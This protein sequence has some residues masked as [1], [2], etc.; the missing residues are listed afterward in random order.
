MISDYHIRECITQAMITIQHW[1]SCHQDEL[2][3]LLAFVFLHGEDSE[4]KE[5]KRIADRI[6]LHYASAIARE[7]NGL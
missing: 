7:C 2:L 6:Q 3:G 5:A 1:D 4:R